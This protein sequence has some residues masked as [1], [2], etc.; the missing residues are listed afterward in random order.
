MRSLLKFEPFIDVHHRSFLDFLQDSSRSG[1]YH[2]S[3][4]AG[5][6]RYL[7]FIAGSLVRYASTVIE[8]H[9]DHKTHFC[10]QFYIVA[11][12]YP[13]KTF[14][15]V[16]EWQQA[17]QPLVDLQ[18]KLLT[19]PNFHCVWEFLSCKTCTGFHT[20][21]DLLLHL[22]FLLGASD[23]VLDSTLMA[24]SHAD[25]SEEI[26]CSVV[27][28]ILTKTDTNVLE[29]DLNACLSSLLPRL[30]GRKLGISLGTDTIQ[31]VCSLLRFDH[32][33]IAM[34]LRSISD[35]QNVVDLID[36]LINNTYLCSDYA[37]D[38]SCNAVHLTLDIFAR[39]P[40]LPRSLFSR[41]TV[42]PHHSILSLF[43]RES[44]TELLFQTAF[45]CKVL[46][47]SH[48]VRVSWVY[49]RY[50]SLFSVV[51][52]VNENNESLS[53]WRKR[54]NP[55][56]VTRIRVM[57]EVAKAIRYLHSMGILLHHYVDSNDIYLDSELHARFHFFGLTAHYANVTR[58]FILARSAHIFLFG[59]LFY[60]V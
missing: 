33:E 27:P 41:R 43:P 17:L 45:I 56:S 21:R 28:S 11:S 3:Q 12:L 14:L 55:N 54:S 1:Q 52:K 13:P 26:H 60:Q 37:A 29:N 47:P 25:G 36:E 34:R 18:N 39:V 8:R 5:T 31:L 9:D 7:D 42:G 40:V 16:E 23:R 30:R 53:Q 6:R 57:L 22:A 46:D 10:P 20:M 32:A 2:I 19:L 24:E 44:Q 49:D 4:Q 58:R 35:A 50:N 48:I 59:C 38:I 51:D 15:P